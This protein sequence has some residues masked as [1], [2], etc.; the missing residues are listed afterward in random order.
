MSWDLHLAEQQIIAIKLC[1][2]LT[3]SARLLRCFMIMPLIVQADVPPCGFGI[4]QHAG[5]FGFAMS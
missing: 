3:K 5:E 2:P 1:T 4:T